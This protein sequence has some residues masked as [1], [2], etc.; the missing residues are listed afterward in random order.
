MHCSCYHLTAV[1][2]PGASLHLPNCL[3]VHLQSF[4]RG[5][6]RGAQDRLLLQTVWAVLHERGDGKDEPLSQCCPLPELTGNRWPSLPSAQG[7]CGEY[8]LVSVSVRCCLLPFHGKLLLLSQSWLHQVAPYGSCFPCA[9]R[10]SV[11]T[12]VQS[13]LFGLGFFVTASPSR[14]N[15]SLVFTWPLVGSGPFSPGCSRC[16]CFSMFLFPCA[17]SLFARLKPTIM[18]FWNVRPYCSYYHRHTMDQTLF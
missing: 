12:L 15:D 14:P 8:S 4:C 18:F 5:G 2:T 3:P 10:A 11:S 7:G 16:R 1:W 9:L 6:V 13:I 17:L